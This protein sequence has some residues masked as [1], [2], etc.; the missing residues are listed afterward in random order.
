MRLLKHKDF[1][2]ILYNPATGEFQ[3]TSGERKFRSG[4]Y[5]HLVI[6]YKGKI[7]LAHRLAWLFYYG[8]WPKRNIDHINGVP[9]DNRIK[10]L[11]DVTHAENLRNCK[12]RVDNTSGT[13]GVVFHKP[14]SKW[15]ARG[16]S[17]GK[18]KSI[19]LFEDKQDAIAAR[20]DWEK[21][22]GFHKNH[23]R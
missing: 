15:Q 10:N 3:E 22:N 19:G 20:K 12:K 14:T 7:Y 11:R 1:D 9:D 17:K 4:K 5:G 16:Y 2:N 8:D 18:A 6:S 23:G 13:T 21:S